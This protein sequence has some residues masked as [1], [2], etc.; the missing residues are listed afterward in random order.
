MPDEQ[1]E[2]F[3][4]IFI[5]GGSATEASA[6][7]LARA[8]L[9]VLVLEPEDVGGECPFTACIRSMISFFNW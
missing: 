8:G 4:V 1:S 5:G 6:P 3:D 9:D 7:A 2:R